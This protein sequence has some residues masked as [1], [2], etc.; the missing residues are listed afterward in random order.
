MTTRVDG[1]FWA[2]KAHS[3][4]T[5][6]DGKFKGKRLARVDCP[7]DWDKSDLSQSLH[8]CEVL[9]DGKPYVIRGIES[10]ATQFIP[11]GSPIGLLVD[12]D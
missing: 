8:D 2:F 6:P 1:I 12:G 10:F 4:F 5:F 3:W 7:F 11:K 9:I